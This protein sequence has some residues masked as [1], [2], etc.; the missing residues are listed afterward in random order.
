MTVWL[1]CLASISTTSQIKFS[2]FTYPP[3]HSSCSQ[4]M[5][6]PIFTGLRKIFKK[7]LSY[8]YVSILVPAPLLLDRMLGP[9]LL[10]N[11]FSITAMSWWYLSPC[12]F[13]NVSKILEEEG[14]VGV[15]VMDFHWHSCTQGSVP[16]HVH[17]DF[18][19]VF[20][21]IEPKEFHRHFL[22]KAFIM[23]SWIN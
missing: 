18:F 12:L 22:A 13:C 3:V 21:R 4:S 23:I 20:R 9:K 8:V 15:E 1:G 2:L 16:Y 6:F 7:P 14:E 11:L 5:W 19:E 17:L 10:W